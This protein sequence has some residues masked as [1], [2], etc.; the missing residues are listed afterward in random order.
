MTFA[1][2]DYSLVGRSDSTYWNSLFMDATDYPHQYS[3]F[4]AT[5]HIQG[6]DSHLNEVT[7]HPLVI[8]YLCILLYI[9]QSAITVILAYYM[10]PL[11]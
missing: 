6:H 10:S 2:S 7:T 5:R 11:R 9:P 3:C 1:V 8:T 4:K